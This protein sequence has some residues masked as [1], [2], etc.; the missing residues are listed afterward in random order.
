MEEL[1]IKQ[2]IIIMV[3]IVGIIGV[4]GYYMYDKF[5]KS[6]DADQDIWNEVENTEIE[7][8]EDETQE[9]EIIVIHITGQVR[10]EG[11]VRLKQ[12]SRIIDAIEAAGGSTEQANLSKVNLAYILE[13]GQKICIPNIN[14]EEE[15]EA[16][17]V[18]Q[19]SGYTSGVIE[20]TKK[21]EKDRVNVN[22][23]DRTELET[24][25][26]IGTATAEKIIQYRE[27]NGKFNDIEDVKKVNGIGD[28]K[29]EKIKEN[30]CVK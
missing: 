14:D 26:G 16:E 27:E 7:T 29:Y 23:A 11:V 10:K 5:I 9:E 19:N 2:K 6:N 24:L 22:T 28:A 17:Y 18:T 13:D 3:I 30:I 1:N 20:Q 25:P 15:I 12:G 4:I 8:G 21:G